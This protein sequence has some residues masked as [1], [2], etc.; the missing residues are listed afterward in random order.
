MPQRHQHGECAAIAAGH[1]SVRIPPSCRLS[2]WM[3]HEQGVPRQGLQ[4]WT[5]TNVVFLGSSMTK[6][7]HADGNDVWFDFSDALV[8]HLPIVHDAGA[9]VVDDNIRNLD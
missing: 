1:I 2:F 7:R 4:R 6:A 8:I 3:P 9:K 5:I